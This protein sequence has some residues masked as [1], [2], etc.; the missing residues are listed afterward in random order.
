MKECPKCGYKDDPHWKPYFF[1]LYWEYAPQED[2]KHIIPLKIEKKYCKNGD[3]Y[4]HFEDH[5]YYYQLGGKTR[6]IIRRFPK[7]Y[8]S[9]VNRNLYEK[10]PSEK[11]YYKRVKK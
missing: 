9:M 2:F 8:E 3:F 1:H 5:Y 11:G 6:K 4:Y 10:T 7:G